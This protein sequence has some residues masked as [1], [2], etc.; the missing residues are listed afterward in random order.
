MNPLPPNRKTLRPSGLQP[1]RQRHIRT[2]QLRECRADPTVTTVLT[3]PHSTTRSQPLQ[4]RP[5]YQQAIS[6]LPTQSQTPASGSSPLGQKRT[7]SQ[8]SPSPSGGPPA[9]RRLAD[10]PDRPRAM[11]DDKAN[12]ANVSAAARGTRLKTSLLDRVGPKAAANGLDPVQERIRS[13][14]QRSMAPGPNVHNPHVVPNG[15]GGFNGPMDPNAMAMMMQPG[16]N[17]AMMNGGYPG[18]L[19]A[20]MMAIQQFGQL[21]MQMGLVGG[22]MG[23]MGHAPMPGQ[24]GYR[25][26]GEGYRGEAGRNGAG[27][28]RNGN[29]PN[30][31]GAQRAPGASSILQAAGKSSNNPSVIAPTPITATAAPVV[32]H[33]PPRPSSPTLCKF[34]TNCTNPTCRY[35]HPS[36]VATMESG[37]V[38]STEPCEKGVDCTDKDCIYA[39]V[40]KAAVAAAK[41]GIGNV[42]FVFSRFSCGVLTCR[43]HQHL[44]QL[45]L[46]RSP[47]CRR[48]R[49][50][51][52]RAVL[53][54]IVHTYTPRGN[55]TGSPTTR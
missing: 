51:L 32:P 29:G 53:A 27:M 33:S 44:H 50:S 2:R 4:T 26:G 36:P 38:L 12:P 39:H 13:V 28:G 16:F 42:H 21:A 55:I 14:T 8:R 19:E 25:N 18:G 45:L 31:N 52:T 49:A 5:L 7:A 23:M 22:P 46:Q 3:L 10:L 20:T 35:S 47:A 9:K 17:P 15:P 34:V 54:P 43:R 37:V 24:S 30:H 40:S 48:L 1:D 11:R 41:S 6:A